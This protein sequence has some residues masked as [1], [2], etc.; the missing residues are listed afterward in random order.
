MNLDYIYTEVLVQRGVLGPS[1]CFAIAVRRYRQGAQNGC[2]ALP[3]CCHSQGAAGSAVALPGLHGVC[4]CRL[5]G[6]LARRRGLCGC[7]ARAPR[8]L[9]L[10]PLRSPRKAPRALR[11][12]CQGSAGFAFA[13]SAPRNVREYFV[14][15]LSFA[16]YSSRSP[17]IG[18]FV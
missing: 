16:I 6:R 4:L 5:H 1:T 10:P 13:A 3:W 7:P 17:I 18:R 12:P 14:I 2:S 8:G 9:P 11:L 15:R